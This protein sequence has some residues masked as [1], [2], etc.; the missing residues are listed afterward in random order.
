MKNAPSGQEFFFH[1]GTKAKNIEEMLEHIKKM[2]PQG[3]A[4]HCD[5]HK[6]DFYNWIKNCIDPHIA[7]DIK[8]VK[9]QRQMVEKLTGHHWQDEHKKLHKY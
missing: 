6:N 3:F 2:P 4:F 1:D 5:E 7:E 9:T 8:T